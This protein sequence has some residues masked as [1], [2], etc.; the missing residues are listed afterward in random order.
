[1][2][3]KPPTIRS[4]AAELGLAP[5][6]VSRA[7]RGLPNVRP[8][9]A[10]RIRRLAG[11]QGY[12]VDPVVAEVMGGLGRA[13]GVHYRET[14]AFV[15]THERSQSDLE[16]RGARAA[17]V[18]L[19]YRVETIKPWKENLTERDVSRILWTRGIRGVLL[20]PNYHQPRPR[21]EL[22]WPKFA[23]VLLGS[24]LVNT[25][26]TRV[27]RDYYHDARLALGQMRASEFTRIGLLLDA[28]IHE[29]T[30]RRYLGAFLAHG[31]G[32]PARTLIV[33]SVGSRAEQ[34]RKVTRWLVQ[35]RIEAVLADHSEIRRLVPRTMP[36]ASLHASA[37]VPGAAG[38]EPDF[39]RVGAEGLRAL[40][41][42]LRAN[43]LGRTVQ[44]R[45]VLVPGRWIAGRDFPAV[46][47]VTVPVLTA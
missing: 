27:A 6:T 47:P 9:V 17:A 21:Y 4:L 36:T 12:A 28:S 25:G 10:A 19:G 13:R 32:S 26:L 45:S 39:E 3:K 33:P 23:A 40:D 38:V 24:S 29:R 15:W 30:D 8:A 41:G 14:V 42:L 35:S 37:E 1:M 20:A 43:Q 18:E 44:P 34:R 22:D 11:R 46:H 7:L 16:E 2:E 5:I 31:G